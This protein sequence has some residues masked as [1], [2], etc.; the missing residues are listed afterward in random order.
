[1]GLTQA[2]A[3][4]IVQLFKLRLLGRM[5]ALSRESGEGAFVLP[6]A[7]M[8][9][10]DEDGGVAV[11]AA[12][13]AQRFA[14]ADFEARKL[15]DCYFIGWSVAA[16]RDAARELQFDARA[17]KGFRQA[18]RDAGV[19]EGSGDAAV[20]LVD[21][22]YAG[23]VVR[24]NFAEAMRIDLHAV[25][26]RKPFASIDAVLQSMLDALQALQARN[27]DTGEPAWRISEQL[28]LAAAPRSYL[29]EFFELWRVSW[30][31]R[32]A[33]GPTSP[34]QNSA[35]PQHQPPVAEAGRQGLLVV[36]NLGPDLTLI[37]L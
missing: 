27:R 7:L 16:S 34:P 28:G 13:L 25:Q 31:G 36:R 30:G 11:T 20:I 24:L 9:L 19:R 12:E 32:R 29:D 4:G 2:I 18:L 5:Q 15:I 23:G 8:L 33:G 22:R 14:L 1:M 10:G 37:D 3:T 6:V 26:R 21:A 35:P 17:C